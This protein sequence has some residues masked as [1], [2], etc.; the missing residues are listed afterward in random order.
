MGEG[1]PQAKFQGTH[2][3]SPLGL[4]HT[5]LREA[6]RTGGVSLGRHSRPQAAVSSISLCSLLRASDPQL[7][8]TRTGLRS[9]PRSPVSGQER[10][11]VHQV[12]SVG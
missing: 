8:L 11:C 2:P 9:W 10:V 3:P 12:G 7:P 1:L 5:G 4:P 6:L